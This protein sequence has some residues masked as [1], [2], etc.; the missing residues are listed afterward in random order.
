MKFWREEHDSLIPS[1]GGTVTSSHRKPNVS[2]S[3]YEGAQLSFS[4][5]TI[6]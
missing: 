2:S 1:L 5:L 3:Q 4:A 6:G